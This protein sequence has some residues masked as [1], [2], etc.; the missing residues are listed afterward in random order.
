MLGA[1]EWKDCA[2]SVLCTVISRPAP[3]RAVID[4]GS[5]TFS[6][7]KYPFQKNFGAFKHR[8][9]L[10]VN[11]FNEEHGVVIGA[12]QD[13]KIGDKAEIFPNHVCSTMNMHTEAVAIRDG[14]IEAIWKIEA[15][16]KLK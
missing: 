16:G 4:A 3:N 12:V 6:A 2:V 14:Q 13:F 11:W 10:F 9:D 15:R 1:A 8:P 5:K 7:D